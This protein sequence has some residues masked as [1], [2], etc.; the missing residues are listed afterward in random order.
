[1]FHMI[2]IYSIQLLFH[3]F[4][5]LYIYIYSVYVYVIPQDPTFQMG[6]TPQNNIQTYIRTY[7]RTYIDVSFQRSRINQT[8][9]KNNVKQQS[10]LKK[11][12]PYK[13]QSIPIKH[14]VFLSEV[15]SLF[16]K[17]AQPSWKIIQYFSQNT[18]FLHN[19]QCVLTSMHIA[20]LHIDS[21][22]GR[23]SRA[24]LGRGVEELTK[25]TSASWLL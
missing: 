5:I 3:I 21:G 25:K 6:I 1:M 2:Y 12:Y 18:K 4:G 9:V 13:I 8:K 10:P 17:I 14:A 16:Q 20:A 19:A 7:I 11:Q 22:R 23:S 15:R 24:G